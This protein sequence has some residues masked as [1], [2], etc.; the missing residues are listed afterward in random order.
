MNKRFTKTTAH[1]P[2]NGSPLRSRTL[3]LLAGLLLLCLV[4][5]F[6]ACASAPQS[7][8]PIVTETKTL[9]IPKALTAR[10]QPAMCKLST[11]GD[12]VDCIKAYDSQ[13]NSCNADKA[14][15]EEFQGDGK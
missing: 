1:L 5:S 11:N 7:E 15:I 3:D 12:L 9:Q 14:R 2:R 6:A 13:L 4:L 8:A 10:T